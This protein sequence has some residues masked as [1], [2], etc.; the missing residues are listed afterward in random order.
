MARDIGPAPLP[1]PLP[2]GVEPF[3]TV[4]ADQVIPHIEGARYWVDRDGP[5]VIQVAQVSGLTGNPAARLRRA[6]QAPGIPRYGHVH[7]DIL[8]LPVTN[9][10]AVFA[11]KGTSDIAIITITFGFL[12]AGG[13]PTYFT[14]EPSETTVPQLEILTTVQ[15]STTEFEIGPAGDKRQIVLATHLPLE[16]GQEGPPALGKE[17][18]GSVEF[19]QPMETVR[20]MRREARSPQWK[21][22]L[23]VGTINQTG[24][25]DDAPHYWMCT[26]LDGVSDDG[27]A[28][29]NVT[30]EFQRNPDTWDPVVI[31]TD[32]ETGQRVVLT[33]WEIINGLA[34]L[35]PHPSIRQVT[36]YRQTN[37]WLLNLTLPGRIGPR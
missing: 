3:P 22:R 1:T 28:T 23:Y 36:V 14:N 10:E 19:Q 18:S 16:E 6:T 13:A 27:G 30:Y 26:R 11:D 2:R 25:F 7:P 8:F 21:A 24:V 37:F 35:D 32:P 12:P 33:D 5:H 17:Q 29:F 31:A 20:Y 4:N 34:G 15:P 9:I